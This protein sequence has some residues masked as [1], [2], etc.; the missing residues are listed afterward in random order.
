MS[1]GAGGGTGGE[2][3]GAKDGPIAIPPGC[4]IDRPAII[5]G[6]GGIPIATARPRGLPC[7]LPTIY[8]T[9]EP[10]IGVTS[11]GNLFL[12]PAY[13]APTE[14]LQGAEQFTGLG[15]ARSLDQGKTFTRQIDGLAGQEE[16]N[17]HPYTADPFM[18]VDPYTDRVFM[19]DLAVPPFN[20]SNL[21][22]SDDQG[23]SWTQTMGGCLVWDHVGY[24]SGPA[25]VSQPD[26]PVVIQRCAITMMAT[27]LA[28]EGTGCQ[29]TLDGGMTWEPPGDP[30]FFGGPD[31]LPYAP[32]TCNG[33]AHH[34]FVDHRGWTWI[35]RDWCGTGPWVA[36]SK[37]EGATWTK[38]HVFDGAMSYHDVAVGADSAGNAYAFWIDHDRRPVLAVS[39]DDGATWSEPW[40]IAPPGVTAAGMSNIAP[41]GAG[42][43][44]FTY[45]ATFEG[46]EGVHAVVAA[47][48]GLDT[49]HPIF[50][51][52]VASPPDSPINDGDCN[53]GTCDGE[54]DFLD[55]T[56]G[57]D[58]SV[59]GSYAVPYV[60]AGRLWGAPSLWD[61]ADP[62]GVYGG[63][64]ESTTTG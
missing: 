47:G 25:T 36:M 53:A 6:P 22:Y 57:P 42:K 28:S 30:A 5:H 16:A 4:D 7:L 23:E 3:D 33:A 11:L 52:A 43:A 40:D 27:T 9:G 12:Y 8:G 21:S 17:F 50:H 10:S 32:G 24:G 20:C 62:N 58:G 34:V 35:G 54:T 19:E 37:D 61:D 29:K 18:Y 48:Y 38:S 44:G 14:Q 41:G 31:G 55:A 63:W 60:A 46:L 1:N 2:G 26:Y 45:A 15:I 51:S 13:L 64:N 56:I 59:W 49:E 39:K